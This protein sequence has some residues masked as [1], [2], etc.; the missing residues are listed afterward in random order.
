MQLRRVIYEFAELWNFLSEMEISRHSQRT[1]V[2]P[3][4]PLTPS[5]LGLCLPC[6]HLNANHLLRIVRDLV[7]LYWKNQTNFYSLPHQ[8]EVT[9]IGSLHKR[10]VCVHTHTHTLEVQCSI[11]LK[12]KS[13][14]TQHTFESHLYKQFFYENQISTT[15]ISRAL[16]EKVSWH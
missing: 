3:S 14:H 12:R 7:E 5:G 6:P 4:D 9:L 2:I 10:R 11:G 1:V 16:K 15:T 13:T 8:Q